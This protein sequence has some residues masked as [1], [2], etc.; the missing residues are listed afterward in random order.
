MESKSKKGNKSI[1]NKEKSIRGSWEIHGYQQT[2]RTATHMNII[3]F[4][5]IMCLMKIVDTFLKYC[6]II[7]S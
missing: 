5:P 4:S 1:P 3:T 2:W 7:C 6:F